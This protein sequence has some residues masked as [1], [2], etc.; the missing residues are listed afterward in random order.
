MLHRERWMTLLA[1]VCGCLLPATA[2]RA[3]P[4]DSAAAPQD[5]G[6]SADGAHVLHLS[7]RVVWSRC[8]EGMHWDGRR[9]V[10]QALRLDHAGALAWARKRAETEGLAWRLPQLKELQHLLDVDARVA[11]STAAAFLPAPPT[12][13][14]W[15]ATAPVDARALNEYRYGNVMRGLTAQN[16]T[17]VRFLHG[18]AVNLATREARDDALKRSQLLVRLVAPLD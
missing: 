16:T 15:T 3:A 4:G 13:W 5:W 6:Y 17:Q 1:I 10:G 12:G 18:W 8:V 9:C 11:G 14:C 7:A 2:A